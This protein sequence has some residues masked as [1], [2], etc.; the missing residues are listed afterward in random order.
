MTRS[1]KLIFGNYKFACSLCGIPTSGKNVNHAFI[2]PHVHKGDKGNPEFHTYN[3]DDFCKCGNC[4]SCFEQEETDF[5]I[6]QL[7]GYVSVLCFNCRKL[8]LREKVLYQY[9]YFCTRA[10][11]LSCSKCNHIHKIPTST[12]FADF[13]KY[14]FKC[15]CGEILRPKDLSLQTL[16][17]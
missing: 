2:S 11:N 13:E 17:S 16:F 15:E 9:C 6:K 10:Q 3:M 1:E 5:A 4:C 14:E 12:N 7:S 8:S